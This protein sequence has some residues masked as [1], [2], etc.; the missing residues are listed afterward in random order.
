MSSASRC[1]LG[2]PGRG[3]ATPLGHAA[4]SVRCPVAVGFGAV[5]MG[6][7]AVVDCGQVVRMVGAATGFRAEVVDGVCA[8]LVAQVADPLVA[9][10]DLPPGAVPSWRFDPPGR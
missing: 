5:A 4:L 10:E 9:F 3:G 8:G 7:V 1:W 2:V 6:R